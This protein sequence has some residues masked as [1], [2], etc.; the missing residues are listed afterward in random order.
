MKIK[1]TTTCDNWTGKSITVEV[2]REKLAWEQFGYQFHLEFEAWPEDI[3]DI[4]GPGRY[5]IIG[6][7]WQRPLGSVAVE[8]ITTLGGEY[9]ARESGMV[10][11]GMARDAKDPVEAAVKLLC[12]LI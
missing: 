4:L 6:S 3:R 8:S 7:D 9:E 2:D 1:L 10:E 11:G 12:N 5:K